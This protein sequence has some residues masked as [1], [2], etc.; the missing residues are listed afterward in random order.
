MLR[1]TRSSDVTLCLKNEI[2][3]VVKLAV[4]HRAY[5]PVMLLT[6]FLS[7]S[8]R[9]YNAL[10]GHGALTRLVLLPFESH[11]YQGRESVMHCLW[12]MDRWLQK[13]C[14]DGEADET[15]D[16]SSEQEAKGHVTSGTLGEA[17]KSEESVDGEDPPES[18]SRH[19]SGML[20]LL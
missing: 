11:G 16:A 17:G 2:L 7:Q 5:P 15:P 6:S 13:Y 10:K 4:R 18:R 14:T 1:R 20:S 3:A 12:E 8:D 19:W 9:F